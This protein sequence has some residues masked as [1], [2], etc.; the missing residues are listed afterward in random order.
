MTKDFLKQRISIY[1]GIDIDPDIDSQV[2]EMLRNKFNIFLPQRSSLDE[3]LSA[4]ISSHE[5]IKLIL[6]YRSMNKK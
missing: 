5:I 2:V 3:S 1:A 6:K 4:S